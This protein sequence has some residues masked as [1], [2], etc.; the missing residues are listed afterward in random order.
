MI[1]ELKKK[2]YNIEIENRWQSL[3]PGGTFVV[4]SNILD[5]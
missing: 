3:K 1:V 5:I 2:S 4:T